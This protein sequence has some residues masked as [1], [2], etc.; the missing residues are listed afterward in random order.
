MLL[1]ALYL[2]WARWLGMLLTPSCRGHFSF[3][4]L[5]VRSAGKCVIWLLCTTCWRGCCFRALTLWDC[6]NTLTLALDVCTAFF[7]PVDYL[8]ALWPCEGII[9]LAQ[10]SHS[11]RHS[12]EIRRK[13]VK[14]REQLKRACRSTGRPPPSPAPV[15]FGAVEYH[16]WFLFPN[17]LV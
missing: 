3:S 4:G 14:L 16:R 9:W 1:N 15:E 12:S 13:V 6:D 8:N 10:A 11:Y 5:W 17:I 2:E 7:K